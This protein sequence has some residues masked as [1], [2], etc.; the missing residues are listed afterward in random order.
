MGREE[1]AL[2]NKVDPV[3][4]VERARS[5]RHRRYP[6]YRWPLAFT[7]GSFVLSAAVACGSKNT[8]P[9]A[10]Q[11]PSPESQQPA[12]PE[13]E[14]Q[15]RAESPEPDLTG[16]GETDDI[17]SMSLEDINAQSPLS[18]IQFD[19][20]SAHLSGEA[21]AHLDANA[22]WLLRHTSVT[23]LIEGHCDERGTVE[24]NLALGERRA[25]AAHNFLLNMGVPSARMKT[26][27]YG[28]EFPV[29]PGHTEASWAKN[30]R[31]HFVITSK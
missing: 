17:L 1:E 8:R 9:P 15:P 6:R 7:L 3:N 18:D 2:M 11:Y 25:M 21:R 30:R 13:T 4:I 24:Y 16:I 28:K 19:Y 22:K 14:P 10:T 20:D 27:S 23:I 5:T 31:D 12:P 29:D 26:I